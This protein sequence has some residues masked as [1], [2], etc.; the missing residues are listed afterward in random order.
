MDVKTVS[1]TAKLALWLDDKMADKM[2]L[3]QVC[4]FIRHDSDCCLV[5]CVQIFK[6]VLSQNKDEYPP[7]PVAQGCGWS[8]RRQAGCRW[9]QTVWL[10]LGQPRREEA[11]PHQQPVQSRSSVRSERHTSRGLTQ[12]ICD[13]AIT[14]APLCT[15]S[16]LKMQI[17]QLKL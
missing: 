13:T 4:W 1:K 10:S 5:H 6:P 14:H 11:A 9:H 8:E 12:L 15:V 3:E 17:W 2:A 7:I 16:Q